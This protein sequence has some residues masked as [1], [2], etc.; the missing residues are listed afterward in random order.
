MAYNRKITIT[1]RDGL[2][3]ET[4]LIEAKNSTDAVP[5]V[6]AAYEDLT[7]RY[8]GDYLFTETWEK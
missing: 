5:M 3:L 6:I 1:T 8:P 7:K 4:K 2:P